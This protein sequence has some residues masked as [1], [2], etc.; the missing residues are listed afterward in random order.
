MAGWPESTTVPNS[1]GRT[2]GFGANSFG[3]LTGCTET[4]MRPVTGKHNI[5]LATGRQGVYTFAGR[6]G[7]LSS[8]LT[9][10]QRARPRA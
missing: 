2:Q 7:L 6:Y 4:E 1:L 5:R 9:C 8:P 3:N 10:R